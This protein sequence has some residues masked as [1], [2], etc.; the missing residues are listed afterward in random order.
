MNKGKRYDHN[1]TSDKKEFQMKD[2]IVTKRNG[3]EDKK[4]RIQ[5]WSNDLVG[6]IR[7]EDSEKLE[8]NQKKVRGS[9]QKKCKK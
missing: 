9:N 1:W 7:R 4:E 2:K 3:E 5:R 8:T 6:T